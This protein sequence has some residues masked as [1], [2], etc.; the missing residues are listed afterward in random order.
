MENTELLIQNMVCDRCVKAVRKTLSDI[1]LPVVDVDLGVAVV[2]KT[3]TRSER[4]RADAAL[5]EEGFALA[6]SRDEQVA[7][8]VRVTLIRYV[9]ALEDGGNPGAL[10]EVLTRS[11]HMSVSAMGR[12]FKRIHGTSLQK[13]LIR[14]KIE[15]AKELIVRDDLTV[16][17]IAWRLG[18]SSP[19]HLSTQ[20]RSVTG[21]TLSEWKNDPGERFGLDSIL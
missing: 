5:Q 6:R 18:Y 16:S 19:Q 14:L 11:V 21:M 20:F 12:V 9:S 7:E 15:R 4:A 13:F 2:G 8:Q 17:D 3:L 1:G 10:N